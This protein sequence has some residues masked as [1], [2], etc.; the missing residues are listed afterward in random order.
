MNK[1]SKTIHSSSTQYNLISFITAGYPRLST[2]LQAI[3]IFD[4]IGVNIIEVGLPYSVP[5]ADGP[6]IQNASINALST[7]TNYNKVIQL[8]NT[9]NQEINTPLVLFVYYNLIINRGI[10]KFLQQ[11]S[12]IGVQGLLVPDLPIEEADYIIYLCRQFDIELIFLVAPTTSFS[13]TKKVISKSFGCIYLVS[14]TGVTGTSS[15]VLINIED[16]VH[17]IRKITNKPLILGFG[18]STISHIEKLY[19]LP[20]NGIVIGSAFIK[21][22]SST[23]NNLNQVSQFCKKIKWLIEE[24]Q[25]KT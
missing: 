8:I 21:K 12:R 10:I 16:F 23:S 2:T 24:G 3:R 9:V 4:Q 14:K 17:Q 19:S 7:G 1:I 18:I 13:R 5:L 6:I 11:I 22:L 25:E 15:N 20:I